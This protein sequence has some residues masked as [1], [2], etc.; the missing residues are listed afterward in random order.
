MYVLSNKNDIYSMF[1]LGQHIQAY[2][3]YVKDYSGLSGKYIYP[4]YH[5]DMLHTSTDDADAMMSTYVMSVDFNALLGPNHG[6]DITSESTPARPGMLDLELESK[7]SNICFLDATAIAEN[8]KFYDNTNI[9][10]NK[11]K[12]MMQDLYNQ[13][14]SDMLTMTY[15][16]GDYIYKSIDTN[17]HKAVEDNNAIKNYYNVPISFDE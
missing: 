10:Y 11:Y 6:Y 3:S 13:L 4:E 2:R 8:I 17:S 1:Q 12:S 16:S 9:D 15:V 5:Y 7:L 14:L